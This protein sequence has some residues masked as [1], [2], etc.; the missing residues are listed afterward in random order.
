M[1][2]DKEAVA[3]Q[4]E[5]NFGKRLAHT[6]KKVRDHAFE[7]VN[8]WLLRNPDLTR[9]EML[10]MWKGLYFAYWMSDKRP[11]QQELAVG[12]ALLINRIPEKRTVLWMEAFWQTM[13][14]HW[15][16]VDK[17]RVDKFMLLLRINL[18]EMFQVLRVKAWSTTSVEELGNTFTGGKSHSQGIGLLLQFCNIF[19]DELV[20]Q[21]RLKPKP[22]KQ[23]ILLLLG[24]FIKIAKSTHWP[25][26]AAAIHEHVLRRTPY[27]LRRSLAK[28]VLTAA[29]EPELYK[30]RREAL[31]DTADWLEQNATP[32]ARYEPLIPEA[33]TADG[34]E[35]IVAEA[36]QAATSSSGKRK[37]GKSAAE[38]S[39]KA[40]EDIDAVVSPLMLPKA[41]VP[42]GKGKKRKG[43][44]L[45][46]PPPESAS[47]EEDEAASESLSPRKPKAK[48][49]AKGRAQPKAKAAGL[50]ASALRAPQESTGGDAPPA[51]S[52]KES[53]RVTWH[54]K[55]NHVVKFKR[56]AE[57]ASK[58]KPVPVVTGP[59]RGA[60]RVPKK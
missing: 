39:E 47:E 31:Y 21:L 33:L 25:N 23:T 56:D 18:A 9:L 10:K 15:E 51:A 2:E 53:K 17:H 45:Q 52:R 11:V 44:E 58:Q 37:R 26:L 41:A 28:E 30:D 34:Q 36:P 20:P 13:K 24:C 8:K 43:A 48:G 6:D 60:L 4:N 54:T 40:E 35:E 42:V 14:V 32:S 49:K 55:D 16:K 29:A 59:R 1:A 22:S 46:L 7:E 38:T 3:A 57:V 19:W 27:E 5:I 12:I 50:S